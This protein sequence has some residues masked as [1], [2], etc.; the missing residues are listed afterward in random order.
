MRNGY[1]KYNATKVVWVAMSERGTLL[2]PGLFSNLKDLVGSE[3]R[4]RGV[5]LSHLTGAGNIIL[6]DS[7][8]KSRARQRFIER[9][10]EPRGERAAR[11]PRV[12]R[13]LTG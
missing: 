6:P 11:D 3:S 12:E 5:G 1:S 9:S 10:A 7:R 13:L 4:D 2:S 8:H